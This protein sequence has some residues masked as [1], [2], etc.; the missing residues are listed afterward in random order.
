MFSVT[1]YD[2]INLASALYSVIHIVALNKITQNIE[3][4]DNSANINKATYETR[5]KC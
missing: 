2:K 5:M 3:I 1:F 4:D